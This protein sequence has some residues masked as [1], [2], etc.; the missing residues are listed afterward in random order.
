[1]NRDID[2]IESVARMGNASRGSLAMTCATVIR[3]PEHSYPTPLLLVRVVH[4]DHALKSATD[5]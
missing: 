1:M 2:A 4:F 3:C 5:N